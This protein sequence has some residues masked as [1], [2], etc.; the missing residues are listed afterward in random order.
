MYKRQVHTGTLETNLDDDTILRQ[1]GPLLGGPTAPALAY[2]PLGS[3]QQDGADLDETALSN[4]L[5][6]LTDRAG[7][8]SHILARRASLK[9]PKPPGTGE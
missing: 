5:R 2:P 4:Q 6:E 8:V 1:P 9:R 3:M 7:T